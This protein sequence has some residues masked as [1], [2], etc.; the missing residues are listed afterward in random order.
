MDDVVNA[1]K[2]LIPDY[3]KDIRLNLDSTL[4]RSSLEKTEALG[5]A[6]AAAFAAKNEPLIRIIRQSSALP[7]AHQQG[8][9][10]ASALMGMNN[11]WYPY[12]E[13]SGSADLQGQP[14]GLRM[15]AYATHG[16]VEK[17]HFEM[18]ALAASIIGRCHFCV[19]A[20]FATLEKEGLSTT[21]LKDIGRLVATMHAAAQV[22]SAESSLTIA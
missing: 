4:A 1:I 19:K 11:I 16:G 17:R 9:L 2:A 15:N 10:S 22:I 14:A 3:A 13:M 7:L 8:A 5:V 6:L 21:Q 20:H 12:I 18:Y